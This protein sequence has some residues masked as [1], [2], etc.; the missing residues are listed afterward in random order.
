MRAWL[1]VMWACLHTGVAYDPDLHGV[2]RR[3]N[4]CETSDAA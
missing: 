4:R 2:E 1:R 3:L